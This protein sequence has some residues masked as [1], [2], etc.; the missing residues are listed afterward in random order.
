MIIYSLTFLFFILQCMDWYTTR[1]IIKNGGYEQ[2]PVMVPLFKHF[3]VD[4]TMAIKTIVV[5]LIGYFLAITPL[6]V[7][8]KEISIDFLIQFTWVLNIDFVIPAPVLLIPV[9]AVY[10]WVVKHNLKSL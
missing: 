8:I 5:S 9:V 6:P 10:L 1:T 2:N 7:K 3:G 4:V